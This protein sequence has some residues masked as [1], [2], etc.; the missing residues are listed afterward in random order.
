M[1]LNEYNQIIREYFDFSDR[2]T[3][4]FISYM[5]ESDNQQQLLSALAGA[6]YEKIVNK[7]DKIDFGSIPRSRGDITKIDGYN[8]TV[9]CINIIRKLVV[10]YKEDPAIIDIELNAIDAVKSLRPIFMKAFNN[11]S[12]FGMMYYNLIVSS[13][14]HSVSFLISVAIQ[15]VK[16]PNTKNIHMA[17]D[18]AAYKDAES[19][20][21][22]ENLA[23]LNKAFND[24]S[25]EK[26]LR[27]SISGIRESVESD[28]YA[29]ETITPTEDVTKEIESAPAADDTP[30]DDDAFDEDVMIL[31]MAGGQ[32]YD[33]PAEEPGAEQQDDP[34]GDA[35]DNSDELTAGSNVPDTQQDDEV[36]PTPVIPI[37]G[38]TESEGT[39]SVDE[40]KGSIVNRSYHKHPTANAGYGDQSVKEGVVDYIRLGLGNLDSKLSTKTKIAATI[41]FS[42]TG[43]IFFVKVVIPRIRCLVA[44][45]YQT[46]ANISESLA[47]Q[48]NL[49]ELNA[50]EL[51]NNENSGLSDEKKAKVVEK[52]LKIAEKLRKLSE[53]FAIKDK[54]AQKEAEKDVKEEKKKN[55]SSDI[56]KNLPDDVANDDDLF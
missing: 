17:L 23:Q 34:F 21:V 8:N 30:V 27:E 6:L 36:E 10:Q 42:L 22:L 53:F 44:F 54:K 28:E 29:E 7:A 38:S 13:I 49:I 5:N 25:L 41:G 45:L 19:N 48:A 12:S 2:K 11:N 4:K 1:V 55:K 51:E 35:N 3:T 20:M 26:L 39:G 37:N 16:D 9:E 15:F 40:G 56:Q 32:D 18:R 50:L 52:Q 14:Q 46:R 47:I 31:R 33:A 24:G 43:I